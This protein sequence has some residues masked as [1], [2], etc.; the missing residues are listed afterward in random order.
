MSVV[1]VME[2]DEVVATEAQYW[3]IT[4]RLGLREKLPEGCE[5]HVAG[6]DPGKSVRTCEVWASEE[7]H[8]QFMEKAGP[9]FQ[10]L[11]VPRPSKVTTVPLIRH[12]GTR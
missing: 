2:W 1:V 9:A 3:A 6:E 4:D 12:L 8:G 11:G 10:D 5:Y 7:A